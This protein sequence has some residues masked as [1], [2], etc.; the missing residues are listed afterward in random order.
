[1]LGQDHIKLVSLSEEGDLELA[2]LQDSARLVVLHA[3]PIVG[4]LHVVKPI[5]LGVIAIGSSDSNLASWRLQDLPLEELHG[6]EQV[7]VRAEVDK[8]ETVVIEEKLR[9]ASAD[10]P[11]GQSSKLSREFVSQ[12]PPVSMA[13]LQLKHVASMRQWQG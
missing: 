4:E 12:E 7:G 5:E 2:I 10:K 3:E 9:C 8:G 11:L 1:M 13:A 6:I